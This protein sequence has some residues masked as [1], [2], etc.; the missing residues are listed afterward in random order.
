MS[1]GDMLRCAYGE[2]K[3]AGANAERFNVDARSVRR[4]VSFVAAAFLHLQLLVCS[5]QQLRLGLVVHAGCGSTAEEML[6]LE[7]GV[8]LRQS[9]APSAI[10]RV[11]AAR[12]G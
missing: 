11:R 12:L 10:A 9:S 4:C 1:H 6:L 2:T 5:A 3:G 8:C 7:V